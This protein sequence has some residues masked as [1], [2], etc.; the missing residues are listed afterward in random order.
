M[1]VF[2]CVSSI[3][4]AIYTSERRGCDKGGEG[5]KNN[6][7]KSILQAMKS[8]KQEPFPMIMVDHRKIESVRDHFMLG[9]AYST[10]EHSYT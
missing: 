6:P 8:A 7:F 9:F 10:V 5:S 1:N 4:P 3:C 2:R